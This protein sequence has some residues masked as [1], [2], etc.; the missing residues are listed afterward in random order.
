M[1]NLLER[2]IEGKYMKGQL[3]G[4]S[5]L[6]SGFIGLLV[7]VLITATAVVPTVLTTISAQN[8]STLDPTVGTLMDLVPLLITIGLIVTIVAVV[9][10]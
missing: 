6:I 9:R 1:E 2:K 5:S 8:F 7:L 10:L 3:S 4:G